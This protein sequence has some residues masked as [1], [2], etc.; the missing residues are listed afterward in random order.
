MYMYPLKL[1]RAMAAR[2]NPKMRQSMYWTRTFY[3]S[4]PFCIIYLIQII[5]STKVSHLECFTP[6]FG[7]N[8]ECSILKLDCIV[9]YVQLESFTILEVRHSPPTLISNEQLNVTE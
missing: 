6:L 3:E 9:L 1:S 2:L 5:G 4:F 7:N 8:I